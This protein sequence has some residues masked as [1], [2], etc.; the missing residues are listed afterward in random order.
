MGTSKRI[1]AFN[2]MCYPGADVSDSLA[3]LPE[4][5][6]H[7]GFLK[8]SATLLTF[9][10][11]KSTRSSGLSMSSSRNLTTVASVMYIYTLKK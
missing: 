11:L 8:A 1:K 10:A 3:S 7:P 6:N 5:N 2:P 9:L 4:I